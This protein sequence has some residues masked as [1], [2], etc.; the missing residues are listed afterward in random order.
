MKSECP[1]K[2]HCGSCGWSHIPYDNQL[3]QKLSDIN[4]SFKLKGLDLQVE[5]IMPSPQTS[6][7][8]NRMDFVIDFEGRVGLREKGKWWRVIDDH[9][10][11]IADEIIE[12]VFSII[13]I[14]SKESGLSYF[15]RKSHAGFLR[16]A[17]VRSTLTGEVM[18]NIVTS[19]PNGEEGLAELKKL[20]DL[21]N[22]TTVI[23]SVNNTVSDVSYGDD[24]RVISG[25][26]HIEESINGFKYKIS[27]NAFF[28]TNPHAAPL[29]MDTVQEFAGDISNKTVLDLYCG[30][31]F[32]SI[33]LARVAGKV[34]GVE[35]VAEAIADARANAE[36]NQ[37][38]IEFHDAKTEEFD[39]QSL[40]PDIVIIDPPRS[41]MHDKALAD[42]IQ[43]KPP[44]IVYVSCNYKNLARELLIL[45]KYYD[46]QEIR[47]IDMFPHTPHVE[48]VVKLELAD[49]EEI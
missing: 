35:L 18:V 41:G 39:W 16:Y 48:V 34:I 22:A 4:G 29:L 25:P 17:V 43:A 44:T 13:R 2:E 42:L 1:N 30:T 31:G 26:G 3:Q 6:H 47:A 11:F 23:W 38:N 46:V 7:Y 27:P 5:E 24:V 40:N 10:C 36:M 8:R 19:A 33:P 12:K 14:W 49:A 21:V 20:V 15:D 45:R 37:V 32:F 28:Q 9:T